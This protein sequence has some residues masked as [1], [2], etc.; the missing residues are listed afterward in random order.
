M[1]VL[2]RINA[3]EEGVRA[4]RPSGP[5][6]PLPDIVLIPTRMPLMYS[7]TVFCS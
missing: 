4:K 2:P 5:V 3:V 6:C 1:P 7:V